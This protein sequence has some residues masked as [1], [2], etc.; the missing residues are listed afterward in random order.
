LR[1]R[2]SLRRLPVLIPLEEK[3]FGIE[4]ERVLLLG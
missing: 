4:K 1:E 3:L 2:G